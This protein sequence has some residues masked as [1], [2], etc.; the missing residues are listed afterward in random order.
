V[1][2][3]AHSHYSLLSAPCSPRALCE[4]AARLGLDALALV[5]GNGLYGLPDFAAQ[6]R[7]VGLRA[8]YGADLVAR[9]GGGAWR[10]IALAE[11]ETGY[12]ALCRLVTALH[13]QPRF[14]PVWDSVAAGAGL[15]LICGDPDLLLR[16]HGRVPAGRLSVALPPL[17]HV[18]RP[19]PPAA[20]GR[21][22]PEFSPFAARAELIA[23]AGVLGL[24]LVATFDVWRATE[25]DA[26]AARLCFAVKHGRALERRRPLPGE[27]LPDAARRAGA[28]ADRPDAVAAARALI[29]ACTL[30]LDRPRAP[31]F[32]PCRVPDDTTPAG[33]LA[34]LAHAGLA[35]RFAAPDPAML[36]RLE[37]ELGVIDAMGF[38]PYFLVVHE[39]AELA[40]ARG[41]GLIGRG[42]AADS[43]VS[44]A[45]GL[46]DA[47][48]I[49][50][51]LLFE[52]FLN[53]ARSDLPDIDL[54]FCWRRRDELIRAVY[55][56]WGEEQVAMIATHATFGPRAAYREAA[57]ALGLPPREVD[58]RSA[59]LPH[60]GARVAADLAAIPGFHRG[61]PDARD[62]AIGRAADRLLDAPR[63]LGVHPGGIVITPGPLCEHA[64]LERA[65]K[66][67][68]VTQY[69][70]RFVEALGLV[71]IDLLG[72]RA[73]TILADAR[74]SLAALGLPVP[75]TA[76]MRED[77]PRTAAMLREGR[78]LACFQIESPG[79]RTL[80]RQMRADRMDHLIQAIA[81]IRPGPA[82]AGMKERFVRRRRGLEPIEAPHPV[83]A[84]AFADTLGIMLYQEDVIR[85]A[86]A[87]AGMS[88]AD[89]DHLRR[90]LARHRGEDPAARDAFVVA[91]LRHGIPAAALEEVWQAM[92][93]FAGFSFCK[94]HSVTY[95]R[96][97]YECAWLKAHAPAA[98]LAAML[99]NDSGYYDK[100]VYVEEAKRLRIP[101]LPPCVQ[102]G[103]RAFALVRD[104]ARLA[105]RV[106]LDEVRALRPETADAIL[107]AR[108]AGGPFTS[109]AD[110]LARTGAGREETENLIL[111][112][113]FDRLGRTRPQALLE[114]QL[115]RNAPRRHELFARELALP[116][117]P[118]YAPARRIESELAIL[119]YS[120]TAHPVDA[121]WG[122]EGS[123]GATPCALV[124]DRIGRVVT[125]Y[126]Q[127]VALR[128]LRTR[129][130]RPMLFATI[131][132]GTGIVEATLFPDAY[133]RWAGELQG[134][135][136]F[137][138]RGRVEERDDG[139]SLR[140]ARVG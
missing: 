104:G 27:A 126:G 36:A 97:A 105:I 4:E 76:A 5:D 23:A 135:G 139:I 1:L 44:F 57:K 140:I 26:M 22:L 37:R 29:E 128:R 32:P 17:D 110:F 113:G 51:G 138:I 82:S 92:A 31:V 65:A 102:Q 69:D 70:M 12:R 95:G 124:P 77:D 33:H 79:M 59:L 50:Y 40:R 127:V 68:V 55:E 129:T 86:M 98:F 100:G 78:T 117:L 45:L 116:P 25:R 96:L 85:A 84:E 106:G 131:E 137:R 114:L 19:A 81:L 80:L 107:Q 134:R 72:N 123:R 119:G 52:R 94:A 120:T 73:L 15:R 41:I 48:P 39:I 21:K 18:A 136:P 53:P 87:V 122:G 111:C 93:R 74:A 38:A 13:L 54:D 109:V 75:A 103:A 66:G 34:R 46:T 133:E 89:G 67:V 56:R 49:R 24:P 28:H 125:V 83:V 10:L 88:A 91:G 35:R 90:A 58:R 30:A 62:L 6:A 112:G 99:S 101:V 14:D 8:L 121:L 11:D 9:D 60:H 42:S 63:H 2:V 3:L 118:E 16:L 64:P 130:G 47:D 20:A 132:D 71:K 43:L 7:R 108:R 61:A 115:A